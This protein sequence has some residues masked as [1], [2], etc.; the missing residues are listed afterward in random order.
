[1]RKQLVEQHGVPEEDIIIEPYARHTT[2][3]MRNAARYLDYVSVPF[4]KPALLVC[5]SQCASY[6]ASEPFLTRFKRDTGYSPGKVTNFTRFARNGS[7]RRNPCFL[8]LEIPWTHEGVERR[9]QILSILLHKPPL[10]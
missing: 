7:P 4:E 1:M 2:T 3:G 6:V 10:P 8:I 9:N 5:N